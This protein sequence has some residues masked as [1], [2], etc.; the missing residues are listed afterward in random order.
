MVSITNYDYVSLCIWHDIELKL[1]Y[2]Y[3]E[4]YVKRNLVPPPQN[5]LTN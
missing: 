2:M 1:R 4:V 3:D 5:S